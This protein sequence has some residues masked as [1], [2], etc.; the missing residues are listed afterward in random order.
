MDG[1]S[2]LIA[3][4]AQANTALLASDSQ[5]FA[6]ACCHLQS[7]IPGV[8]SV[9][10][11]LVCNAYILP[12]FRHYGLRCYSVSTFRLLLLLLVARGGTLRPIN[13]PV[14]VSFNFYNYKVRIKRCPWKHSEWLRPKDSWVQLKP[15]MRW[16]KQRMYNCSAKNISEQ[17]T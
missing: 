12:L 8:G 5:L 9:G 7:L 2:G 13:E 11:P 4:L 14:T 16:S 10:L 17:V 6:Y 3:D 15:P 1:D